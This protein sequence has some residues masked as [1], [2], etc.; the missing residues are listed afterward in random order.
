[1]ACI[2]WHTSR[3]SNGGALKIEKIMVQ[4]GLPDFE[5]AEYG[6]TIKEKI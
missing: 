6:G 1:M 5:P 4:Y 2:C 3:V